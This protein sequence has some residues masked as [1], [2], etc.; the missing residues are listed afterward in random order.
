MLNKSSINTAINAAYQLADKGLTVIAAPNSLLAELTRL[1]SP[2]MPVELIDVPEEKRVETFVKAFDEDYGSQHSAMQDQLVEELSELVNKHISF[3][4]NIVKPSVLHFAET[5]QK[6]QNDYRVKDPASDFEIV[7]LNFPAIIDDE[8]FRDS[9]DKYA[10]KTSLTPETLLK[11]DAVNDSTL[12]SMLITGADRLDKLVQEWL[13][14]K[15]ECFLKNIWE[16]FFDRQSYAGAFES[17]LGPNNFE[18]ADT[19]LAVFLIATHLSN[20]VPANTNMTLVQYNKIIGQYLQ[21]AGSALVRRADVNKAYNNVA[22]TL[23]VSK[24][25]LNKKIYVNAPIYREWLAAGGDNTILLG[26]LVSGAD[27]VTLTSVT[28]NVDKFKAEWERYYLFAKSGDVN[29]ALKD[30]KD[31]LMLSFIE[32][33]RNLAPEEQDYITKNSTHINTAIELATQIVEGLQS[34]DMSSINDIALKMIAQARFHYTSAYAILNDIN[35]AAAI[36]PN[37]DVRE[38]ALLAVTNY[39]SDYIAAQLAVK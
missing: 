15:P 25:Q 31:M 24:D 28:A 9:V 19:A 39:L 4:R 3:A 8:S 21:Y 29:K 7:Q 16:C 6:F 13:S 17:A 23:V 11:L 37:I 34:S 12:A 14:N 20:N 36:S 2:A 10:G 1:S 22:K 18:G 30:F 33:L 5:I 26:Q 38:A 27:A 32:D 35:Q